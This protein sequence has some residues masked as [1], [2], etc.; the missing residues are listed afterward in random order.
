MSDV[1]SAADAPIGN[2]AA[3]AK[4]TARVDRSKR[5]S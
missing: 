5:R 3:A 1:V 4:A 2:A